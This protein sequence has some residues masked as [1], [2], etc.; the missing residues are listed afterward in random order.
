MLQK[1]ENLPNSPGIYLF[2]NSQK[3][4]I[5]VGKATSLK[6]RVRS[7]FSGL[8]TPRPI[9]LMIHEVTNIKWIST[10]SV[11]EA[12]ILEGDYIK[13]YRPKYNI[14][15]RD[16]KSWNYL[17]ITKEKFPKLLA[18]REHEM[19]QKKQEALK[20]YKNIFGP[21][22]NLN[23]KA[24]LKILQKIFKYSTCAPNQPR[25][26][27]NNQIGLCLG[28]CT[29]EIT[30]QN[31]NKKVILPLILFLKGQ[32]KNLLKKI[33]NEMKIAAK[34]HNFEEAGR[35]RDQIWS[36]QKIQ[37]IAIL[38]KDFVIENT[39]K[40]KKTIRIEGY[41][42]SN[43]GASGK[44]SSLVV[45]NTDGP[46]KSEYK[47]FNIKT[48]SGQSDVDCL[49]EVLTRR[50]NH[51]EWMLPDIILVDGGKP[52]VNAARQILDEEKMNL[53]IVGI[54]K[55]PTRKKNEFHFSA[56]EGNEETIKWTMQN[57]NLLIKVRDEAHRFAIAFQRSKRKI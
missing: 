50:F 53:P 27:F 30:P 56:K 26:C 22:P 14:D 28:V 57:Q 3:E 6:N 5:Y 21:F 18:M 51:W 55:G 25:P 49:K 37:D 43:L 42:I 15:W 34:K 36:L 29:N 12:I 20:K 39:P 10:D 47:K 52:Q 35:L 7:Y 46:I 48:V 24:T 45:F 38:N 1:I 23:T 13:K 40:E 19:K 11:L 17:V 41:D 33:K 32:K 44:V 2:Y 9:E 8:K 16:D 4:L 54:A 31:Y